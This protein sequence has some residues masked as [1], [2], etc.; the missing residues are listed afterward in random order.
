VQGVHHVGASVSDLGASLRFWEAFLRA[1]ARWRGTL[2]R[3]Y[4]GEHVGL[5]GI[6]IEAAFL[7][8]PGGAL[9][10]LLD[11]QTPDRTP[12]PDATANPGNVHLCLR[13][14][15]CGRAFAHAVACGARPVR[16]DGPVSIDAGP[17][18]GARAAYLRVPDGITLE[19]YQPRPAA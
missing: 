17:N 5:A 1:P 13:V 11:Y 9:L 14:A 15:D 2:E 19:L 18:A 3:P 4:V 6:R 8:L 7:E 16:P 10:E 12:N